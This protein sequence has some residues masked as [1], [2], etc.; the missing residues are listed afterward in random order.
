M[1]RGFCAYAVMLG[2]PHAPGA[3]DSFL[4]IEEPCGEAGHP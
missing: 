4:W 3:L 2:K 1:V